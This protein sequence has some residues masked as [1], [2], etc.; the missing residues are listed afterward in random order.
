[1]LWQWKMQPLCYECCNSEMRLPISN[2]Q[3]SIAQ[4]SIYVLSQSFCFSKS[5]GY[6]CNSKFAYIIQIVLWFLL[7]NRI[8]TID[9]RF[10]LLNLRWLC[11]FLHLN[12]SSWSLL[13][14]GWE[15]YLSWLLLLSLRLSWM[16]RL[17][18]LSLLVLL[19]SLIVWVITKDFN[20]FWQNIYPICHLNILVCIFGTLNI[21]L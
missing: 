5:W 14:S 8:Y 17:I 20:L 19:F 6:H 11:L 1:M 13:K 21:S 16:F 4:I 10:R 2:I 3:S 12:L 9:E 18:I 7:L 15:C